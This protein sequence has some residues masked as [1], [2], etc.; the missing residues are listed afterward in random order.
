MFVYMNLMFLLALWLKRND[1]V[2]VAWGVGFIVISVML[3]LF[4]PD[5]HWRRLLISCLV[6]LW[7][8]R[9]AV[10][11]YLRNKGKQEDFRYAKWRRDWGKQW[12]IRS[13][14]QVFILQG[15]FML[16]IAYPLF[17]I[18][19]FGRHAPGLSDVA[20]LLLWII[21]FAFESVGDHQMMMFKQN[22]INKGK[23][24]NLGLWKYTRHPNY[25]GETVMWWGIFLIAVSSGWGWLA[26]ISP[27]VITTLLVKVS[28][29]P[30]LEKKYSNNPEYQSY[31]KKTSSFIPW[32]PSK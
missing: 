28:G 29:V 13:Y 16:L 32:F 9:L 24:M 19:G 21:G 26:I 22:P 5:Y 31:I 23:V 4:V 15:F 11:L 8:L 3:L 30:M 17:M 1:I 27:V 14:I 2:D 20:G 12:I 18:G 25:F 10:Y 6:A 7:G